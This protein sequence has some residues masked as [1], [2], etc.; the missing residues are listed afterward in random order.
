GR[1]AKGNA[2]GPGNPFGRK[3]AAMRQVVQEAVSEE[4]L[5]AIV[6]KLVEQAKEGNIAAAKLVLAY[7]VGKPAAAPDPDRQDLEEWQMHQERPS[8]QEFQE[9]AGKKLPMDM[10]CMMARLLSYAAGQ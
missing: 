1:F 3:V 4:D 6:G 2:G 5:R 7:A 10:V 8:C 9:E